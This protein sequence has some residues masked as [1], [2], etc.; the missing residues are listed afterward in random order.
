MPLCPVHLELVTAAE[1][2]VWTD[3]DQRYRVFA[4]GD[5]WWH[6]YRVDSAGLPI[7]H[8][9]VADS[10]EAAQRAV[11]LDR[12][13]LSKRGKRIAITAVSFVAAV[14]ALVA[15]TGLSLLHIAIMIAAMVVICLGVGC[16]FLYEISKTLINYRGLF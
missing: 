14:S 7:A 2:S 6:V 9:G 16:A 1:R 5:G 8:L 4:T 3:G 12:G 13:M 15:F 10:Q 11:R